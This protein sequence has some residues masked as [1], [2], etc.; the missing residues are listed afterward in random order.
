MPKFEQRVGTTISQYMDFFG[1][2]QRELEG[3]GRLYVKF[4]DKAE[5]HGL[6]E[7]SIY[8]GEWLEQLKKP[9]GRGIHIQLESATI[10]H[11]VIKILYFQEGYETLPG[12]FITIFA[13]STFRVGSRYFQNGALL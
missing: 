6:G 12:N 5:E 7:N 1:A 3:Y 11:D 4:S 10:H 2:R 13:D 8:I 9:H